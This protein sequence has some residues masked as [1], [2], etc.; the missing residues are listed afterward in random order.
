MKSTGNGSPEL[1]VHNLLSTIRGEVPYERIKGLDRRYID[2]VS[3][4]AEGDLLSDADFVIDTYEPRVDVD[5]TELEVENAEMG[6]HVIVTSIAY[7]TDD[8][9]AEEDSVYE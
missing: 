3:N 5:D 6:A 1:C 2:A 7:A 4:D 8:A 9:D